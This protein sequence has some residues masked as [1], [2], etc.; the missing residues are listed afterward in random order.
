M[1]FDIQTEN[2]R[3]QDGW[4]GFCKFSTWSIIAIIISLIL[5]GIFL[6]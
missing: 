1:A 3:H 6:V 5:M 4:Q 2:A